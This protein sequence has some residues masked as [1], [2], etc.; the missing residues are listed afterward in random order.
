MNKSFKYLDI[1]TAFFVAVLLIS[2][3]VASKIVQVG[4]F[5]FD[6]GTFLFPLTYIFGDVLTEVYG[7]KKARRVIWLG[8]FANILMALTFI[9][10]GILPA[11]SDWPNQEAYLAILGLTPRIVLASLTAY[12]LGEYINSVVLS[13][14]KLKTKG[15]YLWSRTIGS[16]LVGQM[17]DTL[18]FVLIAFYGVFPNELILTMII[19][20]YIF[21]VGIEVLFTPITYKVVNL[22]KKKE[23]ED[24]FDKNSSYNPLPLS[25]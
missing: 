25:N 20:N 9:I 5:S 1:V 6:G 23:H 13:K 15:K 14:L 2:N 18:I 10:I 4:P 21:K 24:H 3:V 11:A 22:L 7:F 12:F 8:F 17:V 19:S 16:T